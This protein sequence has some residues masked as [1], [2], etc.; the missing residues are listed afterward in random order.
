MQLYLNSA[1]FF[2]LS[3][4]ARF[5]HCYLIVQILF[6]SHTSPSL[7]AYLPCF[8]E[9]LHQC[10]PYHSPS[11]GCLSWMEKSQVPFSVSVSLAE[12]QPNIKPFTGE[13]L[14]GLYATKLV[15]G[16]R[17][18]SVCSIQQSSKAN[19]FLPVL[20]YFF[21]VWGDGTYSRHKT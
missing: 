6:P 3:Y 16:K 11:S 10:K 4:T 1:D 14:G 7:P 21:S 5:G 8:L 2:F 13:I 12:M 9:L 20:F 19:I 18:A 15:I 17:V